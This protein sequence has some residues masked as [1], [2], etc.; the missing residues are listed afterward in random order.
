MLGKEKVTLKTTN[1]NTEEF[2]GEKRDEKEV[3][4]VKEGKGGP[5]NIF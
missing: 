4:I 1:T 2:P 3:R 5:L